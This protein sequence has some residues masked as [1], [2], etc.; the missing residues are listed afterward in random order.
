MDLAGNMAADWTDSYRL[1]AGVDW[2]T[3]VWYIG[4]FTVA[5][6]TTSTCSPPCEGPSRRLQRI[7][8]CS[9]Q[10]SSI[11][12][13][14]ALPGT[15]REEYGDCGSLPSQKTLSEGRNIKGKQTVFVIYIHIMH[16]KDNLGGFRNFYVL[17]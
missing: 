5:S 1:C 13:S 9:P 3:A 11:T 2:L 7:S 10:S 15:P 12:L 16:Y 4:T 6:S 8:P 14:V 17:I